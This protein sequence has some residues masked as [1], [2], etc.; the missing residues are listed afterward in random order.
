MLVILEQL[1]DHNTD[2]KQLHDKFIEAKIYDPEA[3]TAQDTDYK[4][5]IHMLLGRIEYQFSE[6]VSKESVAHALISL[7]SLTAASFYDRLQDKDRREIIDFW[8]QELKDEVE[9]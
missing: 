8:M 3:P 1:S 4:K 5:E 6:V 9:Q 2:M 7:V